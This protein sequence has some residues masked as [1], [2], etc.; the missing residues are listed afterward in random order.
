MKVDYQT[1]FKSIVLIVV[2]AAV[3]ALAQMWFHPFNSIFFW[4]MMATLVILGG[5]VS[6]FIAAKQDI[7][8]EKKL[9]DDKYLG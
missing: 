4:K 8:E 3:L 1:L 2:A 6:F 5:L 7:A 9:R